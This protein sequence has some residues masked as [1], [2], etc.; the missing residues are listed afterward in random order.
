MLYLHI[1]YICTAT[2][3]TDITTGTPATGIGNPSKVILL[4]VMIFLNKTWCYGVLIVFT[5]NYITM[6]IYIY[7]YINGI[8]EYGW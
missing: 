4:T 2:K 1:V 3:V 5:G 6:F 7:M 8:L